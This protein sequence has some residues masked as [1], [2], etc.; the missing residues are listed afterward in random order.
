MAETSEMELGLLRKRADASG[1]YV[2]R[3]KNWDPMRGNGDLYLQPKKKYREDA[4]VNLASYA[5]ADQI[6]EMLAIIEDRNV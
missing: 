3:H 1:Y 6:H 5:T 4:N 2:N